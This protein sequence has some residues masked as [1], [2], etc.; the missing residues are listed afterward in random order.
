[1]LVDDSPEVRRTIA[2][3]VLVGIPGDHKLLEAG[4]ATDAFE[5]LGSGTVDLI[6]TEL[7]FNQGAMD[8]QRMIDYIRIE[9]SNVPIIVVASVDDESVLYEV[10]GATRVFSKPF[11]IAELTEAVASLLPSVPVK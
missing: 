2:D 1:M 5:C 10:R 6:I 11:R 4:K 7:R 3:C 8:G 9:D